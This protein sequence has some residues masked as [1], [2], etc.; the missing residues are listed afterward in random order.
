MSLKMSN[1]IKVTLPDEGKRKSPVVVISQ[2]MYFPWIGLL[3]QIRLCEHFI[4]YDD[5]QYARGFFNRVQVKTCDGVQWM[6]VPLQELHRGQLINEVKIDDQSGWRKIHKNLLHHAYSSAPYKDE[7]M[8]LVDEVFSHDFE[9]LADLS[10]ISTLALASYFGINTNRG[11]ENSSQLSILG[12][13]TQRLVD[14]CNKLEAKVYLTGHGAKNYLEHEKFEAKGID[15]AYIDY[16]FQSYPQ[17]HGSFTPYV[18]SLD[19]VANCGRDGVKY[20]EGKHLPWREF[21]STH[22]NQ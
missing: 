6:T 7:M 17:L 18:S 3:E 9:S 12:S 1:S 4:F 8:N 10:K 13:G 19:L 5:V 11:F 22:T 15:V 2:P 14:L 21:I 16:G 20:I